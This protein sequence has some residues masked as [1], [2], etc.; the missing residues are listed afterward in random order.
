L[1][2]LQ[3]I[4]PCDQVDLFVQ[5]DDET[6]TEYLAQQKGFVRKMVTIDLSYNQTQDSNCSVWSNVQWASLEM[7]KA[8]PE[9]ELAAVG[10]NFTLAFGYNPELT[11]FPGN[12][13]LQIKLDVPLPIDKPDPERARR[14]EEIN[15]ES[16]AKRLN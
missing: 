15:V 7:W 14:I 5:A 6:W 8:I 10:E 16:E 1:E 9:Q 13:G 4:L 11:A 12:N 3:F 2:Q